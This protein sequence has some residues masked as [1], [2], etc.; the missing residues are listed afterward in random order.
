MRSQLAS[1]VAASTLAAELGLMCH[2]PESLIRHVAA[3]SNPA[4]DALTFSSGASTAAWVSPASVLAVTPPAR[5]LTWIESSN[6]RLDF[7]RAL[8]VLQRIG[9][10]VVADE[11]PVIAA[12]ARIAPSVALGNGV[13][14]GERTVIEPHVTIGDDVTIGEDCYIKSGSVLG[15][16]GFGFARQDNGVPLRMLHFGEVIIGDR[17]EIGSL[18]TVVR[19]TLGPTIVGNDSKFDDHV[20][21]AHN[22]R[23]GTGVLI[24]ACAELSGGVTV[25]DWAW[26]GPNASLMDQ[27]TIGERATVGLGAVVIRDVAPGATVAGNPAR[28]LESRRTAES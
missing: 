2:G 21:V 15:Q 27:I 19:G 18:N 9:R 11:A 25:G 5:E 16:P 10:F 22:C 4:A 8:H 14:I 24:T 13:V 26:I 7:T 23:I 28:V 6:P 20:H 3:L 1:P 12:S 17:V